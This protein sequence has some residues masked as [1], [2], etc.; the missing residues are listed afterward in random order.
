MATNPLRHTEIGPCD[1]VEMDGRSYRATAQDKAGWYLQPTHGED[2]ERRYLSRG[3]LAKG[4]PA[5][6]I[7]VI[8]PPQ[9]AT[10]PANSNFETIADYPLVAR[11]QMMRDVLWVEE[12]QV[13]LNAKTVSGRSQK[14]VTA[15]IAEK[16]NDI[17]KQL[18]ALFPSKI[19]LEED[20]RYGQDLPVGKQFP[21]P[22]KARTL[23]RKLQKFEANDL[24]STDND[25]MLSL[26]YRLD[27]CTQGGRRLQEEVVKIIDE[28]ATKYAGEPN[29][30]FAGLKRLVRT[31]IL[32]HNTPLPVELHL[33]EPDIKTLA[34]RVRDLPVGQIIG[35]RRTKSLVRTFGSGG[36]G[37]KYTRVGERVETD[38]W[39][40]P[41][42]LIIPE[43]AFSEIPEELR[44][45]ISKSRICVAVTM[46]CAS[47]Y[48]LGLAFGLVEDAA[49]TTSAFRMCF[50]DRSAIAAAAGCT[51]AWNLRC[52]FENSCSDGGSAYKAE[53]F[54][55][56]AIALE[57]SHTWTDG[58]FPNLR[59]HIESV[60]SKIHKE[61]I[62]N[63]C[64]RAFENTTKMG[65]YEGSK[66][67]TMEMADFFD[68]LTRYIVDVY[69]HLPREGGRRPS[70][71]REFEKLAQEAEPAPLPTPEKLLRAFG[72]AV[73]RKLDRHGVRFM[74]V[75]YNNDWLV[76]YLA[77]RGKTDVTIKIDPRNIGLVGVLIEKDWLI[78]EGPLGLQGMPLKYWIDF[79]NDLRRRIGDQAK[80]DFERYVA[81]ALGEIWDFARKAEAKLGLRDVFWTEK[82]LLQ[83]EGQLKIFIA[84]DRDP[85]RYESMPSILSGTLGYGQDTMNSPEQPQPETRRTRHRAEDV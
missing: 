12:L 43:K 45:E 19:V 21:R 14:A 80:V 39:N 51:D 85:Q 34:R 53:A 20:V 75:E 44:T 58:G 46:D 60:F 1:R 4:L 37:P 70:P 23:L 59:G 47:G 67:A 57:I 25:R 31:A 8:K 65:E 18:K 16:K 35:A 84:Y 54:K 71:R 36:K 49:L 30:T 50:E 40:I 10:S 52:G 9:L 55:T 62:T 66:H 82:D 79:N 83:A 27:R 74:N 26:R 17:A 73:P 56:A 63:F 33:S 77:R 42:H 61:F 29:P 22:P 28:W 15:F 38:C 32:N 24:A 13:A 3:E 5:G 41:L 7:V 81:P 6:L 64:G 68:L 78:I 76:N 48:I 69:H 11:M 72:I 2:W